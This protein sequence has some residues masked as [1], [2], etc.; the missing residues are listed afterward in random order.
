L[1]AGLALG[2]KGGLVFVH[3]EFGFLLVRVDVFAAQKN[4]FEQVD[5]ILNQ[6]SSAQN[7]E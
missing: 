6:V 4:A 1:K 3:H 2:C 7:F 5:M